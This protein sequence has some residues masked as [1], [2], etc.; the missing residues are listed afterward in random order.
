[1]MI[2]GLRAAA[3]ATVVHLLVAG[4]M[5][6]MRIQWQQKCVGRRLFL[7]RTRR[8]D[9]ARQCP[10][11]HPSMPQAPARRVVVVVVVAACP[12]LRRTN[13]ALIRSGR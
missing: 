10:L 3:G 11:R 12:R 4:G 9:R 8:S 13:G 6:R 5:R 1:M 7:M 2:N